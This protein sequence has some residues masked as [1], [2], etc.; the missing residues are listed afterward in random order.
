MKKYQGQ[1]EI[2]KEIQ[3]FYEYLY[4]SRKRHCNTVSQFNF[5]QLPECKTVKTNLLKDTGHLMSDHENK[6][7]FARSQKL[8]V[9]W[10][11]QIS[12]CVSQFL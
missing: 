12:S 9:N 1:K 6:V 11:T 7:I 8:E 3:K 2:S 4:S 5:P 10:N